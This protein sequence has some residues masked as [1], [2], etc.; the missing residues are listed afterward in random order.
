MSLP[1]RSA[2]AF[3]AA[4]LVATAPSAL[5]AQAFTQEGEDLVDR[6]V[7]VVGD[8]VVLL[9][10]IQTD[11]QAMALQGR[12]LPTDPAA[13]QQL[14]EESVQEWVNRVLILQAAARDTL[15]QVDAQTVEESVQEEIDRR[16]QAFGGPAQ[17]QAALSS[18][19]LTLASYRDLL[20]NQIR[21]EQIRQ[22]FM[23]RRIQNAPPVVVSDAELRAAFEEARGQLQE[24][25]RL[26]TF[27]QVVL[28]PAPSDSADV[29]ALRKAEAIYDSIQAG[30]DFEEM[31]QRHSDDP[32]SAPNGGDLDWFRRGT[33]V[34]EFEDVAFALRDG[35]VSRPVKTEFGY[36][37]IKIERSR[38]G[39]RNGRHILIIPEQTSADLAETRTLADSVAVLARTGTPMQTLYRDFS[40]AE[41]PDTL[42]VTVDQ[43]TQLPPGY[44]RLRNAAVGE[45]VGPLEYQSA[46][47]ETR[48]AVVKLR[49]IREAGEYTFEDVRSQ[50]QERLIQQKQIE[51]IVEELKA[52]AYIDIRM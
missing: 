10:Q 51:R 27:A 4:A 28:A 38:L 21:Q 23:R 29:L 40:D 44:D 33:M 46:R 48:F 17:M 35:Q 52:R 45:V 31:A 3:L 18:E 6:V 8:S 42:T 5:R 24:R 22:M 2:F 1:R 15:I 7:A 41:A 9:S 37:I 36:H 19:G 39:E 12:P 47:G 49:E 50:L 43:L 16:T 25:P 11:L 34:R 30:A 26:V 13:L 14:F 20:A 32:G